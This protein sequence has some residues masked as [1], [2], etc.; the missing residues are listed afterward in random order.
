M[1]DSDVTITADDVKELNDAAV[2][3][4]AA[5]ARFAGTA[6]VGVGALGCLAWF[7]STVR[8]QQS[9]SIGANFGLPGTGIERDISLVDRLDLFAPY[10]GPI[11]TA[12]L[13][14]GFGLML[15]LVADFVVTRMGGSVT[16][17]LPGDR[18]DEEL[19][20]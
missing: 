3:R 5:F 15:R 18:F 7:W 13:V 19:S 12:A 11:V 2:V 17:F 8:A 4:A 20:S 10:V 16:G 14:V 6:L 9:A 1:S